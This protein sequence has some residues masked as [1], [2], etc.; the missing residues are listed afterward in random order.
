MRVDARD[1]PRGVAQLAP[2]STICPLMNLPL[3]SPTVP[4]GWRK[5]G[6]GR[7][8]EKFAEANGAGC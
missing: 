6:W 8:A 2:F 3:Y 5:P 1:D 7:K 4:S